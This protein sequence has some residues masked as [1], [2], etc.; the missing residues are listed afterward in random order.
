MIGLDEKITEE[1]PYLVLSLIFFVEKFSLYF[2]TT[3]HLQGVI[4]I[5]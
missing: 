1:V 3:M 2:S 4:E 5:N